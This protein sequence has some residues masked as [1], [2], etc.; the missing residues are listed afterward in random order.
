MNTNTNMNAFCLTRPEAVLFDLDGTLADTAPDLAAALN[1]VREQDGL[2]PVPELQLRPFTSA[3]ARG[4]IEAGYGWSPEHPEFERVRNAFLNH[5]EHHSS[6]H[7]RLFLGI[8]RLLQALQQQGILWGVVTNKSM[9]FV[10]KVLS[11][12]GLHAH[13]ATVIGGDS[14]PHAKPHPAPLLAACAQIGKTPA[15]CLY[16][17]DD[18]RD[19]Q[20]A[21]AAGMPV[22]A[23]AYGYLG[24]GDPP[25]QWGADAIIDQPMDLLSLWA[26]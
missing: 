15:Q 1:A 7:S 24:Q 13:A 14:T 16:V 5:Y 4:L 10:P 19:V 17:G 26:D 9:R 11:G 22:V 20:A 2:P 12:L 21:R 25:T 8:D 23:V 6:L 3:G 18:I